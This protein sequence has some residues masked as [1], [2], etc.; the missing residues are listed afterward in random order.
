MLKKRL[1]GFKGI[2]WTR[3]NV[4]SRCQVDGGKIKLSLRMWF[5]MKNNFS[6]KI[7][8][9][10]CSNVYL[11]SYLVFRLQ[12]ICRQ[13]LNWIQRTYCIFFHVILR[14]NDIVLNWRI[15]S[16]C[17]FFFGIARQLSNCFQISF[18]DCRTLF[19]YCS[20]ISKV[21]KHL[22]GSIFRTNDVLIQSFR[23][24]RRKIKAYLFSI[25]VFGLAKTIRLSFTR[26]KETLNEKWKRTKFSQ[27]IFL[28]K[29]LRWTFTDFCKC[30]L[31]SPRLFNK[32]WINW[33]T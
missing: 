1:L 10:H 9:R 28:F 33:E 6:Q 4:Y 12:H 7:H 13:K 5:G 26:N 29:I 8:F 21:W 15:F 3:S 31:G 32:S 2:F 30:Y 22:F 23:F 16:E 24:Q 20:L 14:K 18:W 25:V 11:F 27:R 19:I 17:I